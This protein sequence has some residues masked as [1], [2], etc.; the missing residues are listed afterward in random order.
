MQSS[1]QEWGFAMT[2]TVSTVIY[3]PRG[4]RSK[5][6]RASRVASLGELCQE[7]CLILG[8]TASE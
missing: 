4:L 3:A 6:P 1:V 2:V 7:F 8:D 5:A